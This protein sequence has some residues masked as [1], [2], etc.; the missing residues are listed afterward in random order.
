ME[1]SWETPLPPRT[2]ASRSSCCGDHSSPATHTHITASPPS[3]SPDEP[4]GRLDAPS[5]LRPLWRRSN[6]NYR[7]LASGRPQLPEASLCQ[8]TFGRARLPSSG[9]FTAPKHKSDLHHPDFPTQL[10][11]AAPSGSFL[12]PRRRRE[13]KAHHTHRMGVRCLEQMLK[14]T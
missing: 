7:S 10:S 4:A 11:Q 13:F 3:N 9:L 1:I 14:G 6:H 8:V 2:K 12:V 5:K